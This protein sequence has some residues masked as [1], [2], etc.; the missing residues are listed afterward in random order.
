MQLIL[1][2]DM[3]A[4]EQFGANQSEILNLFASP[5]HVIELIQSPGLT[6]LEIILKSNG[7]LQKLF[8]T[9][10]QFYNLYMADAN[11]ATVFLNESEA[12]F[13]TVFQNFNDIVALA[14]L[15]T[16]CGLTVFPEKKIQYKD[17]NVCDSLFILAAK[18]S[19]P[20]LCLLMLNL[21]PMRNINQQDFD[22]LYLLMTNNPSIERND[23]ESWK[24]SYYYENSS[25]LSSFGFFVEDISATAQ[26]VSQYIFG[27]NQ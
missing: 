23:I 2:D 6:P 25:I 4:L 27:P 7:T 19:K 15:N 10:Q 1:N 21:L 22:K 16:S 26:S 13:S 3:Q 8:T 12:H 11:L 14:L 20:N 9:P 24:I 5:D 17:A 18:E